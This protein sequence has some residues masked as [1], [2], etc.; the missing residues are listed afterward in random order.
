MHENGAAVHTANADYGASLD[1]TGADRQP[2]AADDLI[3]ARNV[4]VDELQDFEQQTEFSVALGQD[5]APTALLGEH[6][7]QGGRASPLPNLELLGMHR[8]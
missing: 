5:D 6:P 2:D 3:T 8:R 1:N 4:S 7:R